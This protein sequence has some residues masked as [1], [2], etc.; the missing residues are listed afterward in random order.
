[1]FSESEF[2]QLLKALL[3]GLLV[4]FVILFGVDPSDDVVL[5]PALYFVIV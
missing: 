4:D 1:M 5:A 2:A 3:D